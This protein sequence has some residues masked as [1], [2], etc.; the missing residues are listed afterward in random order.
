MYDVSQTFID[1]SRKQGRQIDVLLSWN[2]NVPS[3]DDVLKID[4]TFDGDFYRT[5]MQQIE[6]EIVGRYDLTGQI[7]NIQVGIS[8]DGSPFEYVDWG[9]FLVKEHERVV[10]SSPEFDR[11]T[12]KA[13]DK[14]LLSHTLYDVNELGI[15]FPISVFN[16]YEAIANYLGLE[17]SE[18]SIVN[19]EKMIT[20][21]KWTNIEDVTYRNILD[22]ISAVSGSSIMIHGGK[23]LC[24]YVDLEAPLDTIDEN[25]VKTISIGD[26]LKQINML[27]LTR[28][29]AHDNYVL[30]VEWEDIPVNDRSEI[31]IADNQIM[32][33]DRELYAPDLLGSIQGLSYYPFETSGYGL[34]HLEPLDVVTVIDMNGAEHTS[35]ITSGRMVPTVGNIE[36][37]K[38]AIPGKTKEQYALVTDN[39]RQFM[40]VYFLVDQQNGII[41]GLVEKQ[42]E[43][44]EKISELELTAEEIQAQVSNIAVGSN[45]IYNLNFE[46]D[47][48]GW[49]FLNDG[50]LTFGEKARFYSGA[51]FNSNA[52]PITTHSLSKSSIRFL[53]TGTAISP[54]GYVVP[55]SVYSY[56][57][58][59]MDNLQRY[60]VTVIEYNSSNT[61]IKRTPFN[62][63]SKQYEEFTI[64]PAQNTMYIALQFDVYDSTVLTLSEQM[65]VRGKPANFQES[66]ESVK[67]WAQSQFVITDN[68]IKSMV[69]DIQIVNGKVANNTSSITQQAS[70]IQSLVTDVGN[71][72]SAIT[73]NADN[74]NLKVEKDG[75]KSAINLSPETV[76]ID[77]KNLDFNNA[78][79]NNVNL[80]GKITAT[81]GKIAGFDINGNDLIGEEVSLKP[82]ELKIGS[83]ALKGGYIESTPSLLMEI[84]RFKIS[85]PTTGGSMWLYLNDDRVVT[86]SGSTIIGLFDRI[87]PKTSGYNI[88][89]LTQRYGTIYL[90]NQ[91]N[92]SSDER[93]KSNIQD[94]DN[95]LLDTF[96]EVMPKLFNTEFDNN[97]HFGY[98]AQDVERALYKY[99][100]KKYGYEF[101][102]EKVKQFAVLSKSESYL[103]LL[104]GELTVI[105]DA[106]YHREVER[107][108][109]QNL[110]L[111]SE[112]QAI[113][114]FIGMGENNA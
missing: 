68:Q 77:S 84:S 99:C 71:A 107:L 91:P 28:E 35:V 52:I 90:Q 15:T 16:L 36:E 20:E 48:S 63:V 44:S 51:L 82:K 2:G 101:A 25:N 70:Q 45:I 97:I 22:E 100:L 38:S 73:Q 8:Y 17:I 83:A 80:T 64:Q 92:V 13:Y 88:G 110:A 9:E 57:A 60:T 106:Y 26:V 55:N 66:A 108:K 102:N 12:F 96:E 10:G 7:I 78:T 72:Q 24:K 11:T 61:E 65:F 23:L 114:Q 93:Y 42:T 3:G 6:G 14:L 87:S 113:K 86:H 37:L 105:K 54:K 95:D 103:S 76:K 27:N 53:R 112:L 33:K 5:I 85:N 67:I 74:I 47:M 50:Y 1:N 39:K 32:D 104:Y 40:R 41:K 59:R 43:A 94:I 79:G 4:K 69:S 56:K 46:D 75:V 21:D 30:P 62:L 19:G 34:F 81:S 18:T 89:D 109:L 58:R 31:V 98:I 29:Q 111:Q 49:R